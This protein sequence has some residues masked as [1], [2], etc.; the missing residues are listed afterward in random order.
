M[1]TTELTFDCTHKTAEGT[2]TCSWL[3]GRIKLVE[4]FGTA[5]AYVLID[6]EQKCKYQNPT[7]LEFIHLQVE[8]QKVA[9]GM[10]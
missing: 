2:M 7:I 9:N 1:E 10:I 4:H 8:C 6:G 5:T 3:S